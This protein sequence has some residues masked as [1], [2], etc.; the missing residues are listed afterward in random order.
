MA[1]KSC[2]FVWIAKFWIIDAWWAKLGRVV[3]MRRGV[4]STMT[5]GATISRSESHFRAV[6]CWTSSSA[7]R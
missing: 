1:L 6:D 2:L 5:S 4:K 7:L 3:A